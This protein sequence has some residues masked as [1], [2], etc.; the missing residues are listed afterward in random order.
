MS[1]YKVHVDVTP[2]VHAQITAGAPALFAQ[3]LDGLKYPVW[4]STR[5]TPTL[6][7]AAALNRSGSGSRCEKMWSSRL[8]S[9]ES[10]CG[11]LM[12][13]VGARHRRQQAKRQK[14][15][16]FGS[17][18]GRPPQDRRCRPCG[19]FLV[20]CSLRA[21]SST[22]EGVMELAVLGGILKARRRSEIGRNPRLG[23]FE[24]HCRLESHGLRPKQGDLDGNAGVTCPDTRL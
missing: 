12:S 8:S 17:N 14:Q 18:S 5:S 9:R 20:V 11:T 23:T 6:Q 16:L 7:L 24:A 10:S 13:F 1:W 4:Q 21:G 15:A 3:A 2:R 19:R 22:P